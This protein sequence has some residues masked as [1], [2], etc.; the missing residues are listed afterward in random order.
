MCR[1]KNATLK[2]IFNKVTIV[3][4]YQWRVN[5]SPFAELFVKW[6]D[7]SASANYTKAP[8]TDIGQVSADYS[9]GLNNHFATK[10]NIL[11]TT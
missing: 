2:G 9:S 11:R 1:G 5:H 8:H 7:D 3:I 6:A 4:V 10:H